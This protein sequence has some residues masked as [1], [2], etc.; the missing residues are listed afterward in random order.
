METLAD[1]ISLEGRDK[2][3]AK[4]VRAWTRALLEATGV[5]DRVLAQG[6]N[7]SEAQLNRLA[8]GSGTMVKASTLTPLRRAAV[9]IEEGHKAL[10][11]PGLKRWLSTPNPYLNDVPP[12]LCLRSE[13]ELARVLSLLASIRYGFPA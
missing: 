7:M 6:I 3:S 13:K 12:I 10:T 2:V 11:A 4:E 5:A 1:A 9:V 8:S